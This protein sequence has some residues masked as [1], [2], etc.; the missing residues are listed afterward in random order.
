MKYSATAKP[1]FSELAVCRSCNRCTERCPAGIP[2]PEMLQI[3]QKYLFN[4][5]SALTELDA[6][7]YHAYPI[8]CIECGA[9]SSV[10][11]QQFDLADI[12]RKLAMAHCV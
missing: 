3:F 6:S 8:D 12:I 5:I 9:C 4:G 1:V 2:I 11:P 10:C 7:D